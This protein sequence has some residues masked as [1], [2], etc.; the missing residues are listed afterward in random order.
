MTAMTNAEAR[1]A[2]DRCEPRLP[3][4]DVSEWVGRYGVTADYP[5][6]DFRALWSLGSAMPTYVSFEFWWAYVTCCR[7]LAADAGVSVRDLD[8][9]LWAYSEANQPPGSR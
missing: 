9:A 7:R 2:L 8:K 5:I 1:A 3:L 4:A 6:I